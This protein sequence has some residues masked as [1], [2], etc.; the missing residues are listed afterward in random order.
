MFK[1]YFKTAW[2]N[3]MKSKIFSFINILGLTIGITVC[4][5]IFLFIMN[6]FS[7]DSFHKQ[8]DRIYRVMRGFENEGKKGSVSYLSGMHAPALLNDFKGEIIKAVR[9]NPTDNLVTIGNRSFHEKKVYDVD[10]D[11]FSLFSFPLI[12]GNAATVLKD[13]NSVVLTET[14][15]KKYFGSIDN[16]IGKVVELDK[17][18]PLKVTGIAKDVPSNSHLYFDLVVPLSNY[19]D[20]GIMKTWI[21]NGLFTYVLLDPHTTPQQIESRLPQFIE[22]Y[23]G[24]DMKK[25]GFHWTLSLTP[26]RD[27]YFQN[28]DFDNAKHGDKTVVYIF[29]SIAVLILLIACIN[30]TNLSTIRAVERSKEVGLRKVLGAVRNNLV[31]QFIGESIL[32]TTISCL[33]SLGLLQ[34]AM[35]LYNRLL[36][37]SLTVSW[38]ALPIYLFLA[39][40]SGKC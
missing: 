24:G 34:L 9:V 8:G 15:A 23:M 17:S 19:R 16:A 39:G 1:N 40:H 7:F 14:T 25:Y 26:L 32:L 3:L 11:F 6:E 21:Y 2:R 30:F 20:A 31:W 29:L 33:L 10:S 37:Y 35:P 5:M 36:G 22:K 38:N 4:M 27:V 12:K 13:P 18:L 28:V